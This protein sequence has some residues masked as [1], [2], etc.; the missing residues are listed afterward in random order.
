M[1]IKKIKKNTGFVI[2]FA[3]TLSAILLSIALG[4]SDIAFKELRFGTSAKDTNEAFMAADTGAECALFYELNGSFPLN[5]SPMPSVSCASGSVN[6]AGGLYEF[7]INN[8]G[9]S[10]KNCAKVTVF[11]EEDFSTGFQVIKA[12]ITSKGYNLGGDSTCNASS[13]NLL[14][15]E[16]VVTL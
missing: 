9:G 4:V 10:G 3:V 12:T 1:R 15:R 8:L 6:F 13:P 7:T 5:G 16:I 2:L 11:K 14:E